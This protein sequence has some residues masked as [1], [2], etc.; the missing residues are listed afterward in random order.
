VLQL[1]PLVALLLDTTSAWFVQVPLL[2]E[3]TSGAAV[4]VQCQ[5]SDG[6]VCMLAYVRCIAYYKEADVHAWCSV[7]SYLL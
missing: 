5:P 4:C 7:L 3:P 2:K 1:W 6:Q